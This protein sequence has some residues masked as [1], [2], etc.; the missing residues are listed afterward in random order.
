MRAESVPTWRSLLY[1][2]ANARRF[3]D[4]AHQ[5]G[6]D[7]VILDLEDSVPPAEKAAARLALAAAVPRVSEGGADVLVR[8]NQPLRLAVPDLEAAVLPGV[9]ALVITKVDGASH[10]RLLDELVGE[11]ET[12]GG[13][14][15]GA[16]RFV[17]VVE[18][19]RAW[20]DMAA[21]FAASPRNAAAVLGSEDFSLACDAAPI[22]ETLLVPKQ[23]LIIQ[24]RACGL[25][26]L[27][28]IASVADFSHQERLLAMAQRS[29][30][31]GFAGATCIHPNQVLAVNQAFAPSAAERAQAQRIVEVYEEAER[32]GRGAVSVDGRMVD[33]P[34]VARARRL[35]Q[36][37]PA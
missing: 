16:I 1:V 6:A 23:Q 18:T 15:K 7:A 24:A 33:A 32:E 26:P 36:R 10:L 8:I 31:F 4:K 28:L 34:V 14:P 17:L 5:R 30:R 11:L 2:P 13:L 21:I 3:V 29:R 9:S 12:E 37:S 35:L 22:D 27:G 20:L 19:P 25:V